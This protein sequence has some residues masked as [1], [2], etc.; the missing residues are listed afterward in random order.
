MVESKQQAPAQ[1]E[2]D[3]HAVPDAELIQFH[4]QRNTPKVRLSEVQLEG[5]EEIVHAEVDDFGQ[6]SGSAAQLGMARAGSEE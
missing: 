2:D 4:K 3:E 5:E 6:F 1:Q